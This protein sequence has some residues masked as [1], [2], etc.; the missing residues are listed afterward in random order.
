MARTSTTR[1]IATGPEPAQMVRAFLLAALFAIG[2]LA[3]PFHARADGSVVTTA[4]ATTD[5]AK[6]ACSMHV[7]SLAAQD[8]SADGACDSHGQT[9]H[10][11]CQASCCGTTCHMSAGLVALAT[12]PIRPG[13]LRPFTAPASSGLISLSSDAFRP[14]IA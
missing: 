13:V 11:Y 5:F 4:I 10:L 1:A 2:L 3:S 7:A 12:L 9:A 14:P 8:A 6:A